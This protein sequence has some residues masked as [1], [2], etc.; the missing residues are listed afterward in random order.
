MVQDT[1][2]DIVRASGGCAVDVLTEIR[3]EAVEEV[4]AVVAWVAEVSSESW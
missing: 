4:V 1:D 2:R 3:M